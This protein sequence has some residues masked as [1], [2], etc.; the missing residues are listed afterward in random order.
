MPESNC[1]SVI[2]WLVGEFDPHLLPR[3]E[4]PACQR[5]LRAR[6]AVPLKH[7]GNAVGRGFLRNATHSHANEVRDLRTN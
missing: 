7:H 1:S 3:R 5:R 2:W 4:H 6:H